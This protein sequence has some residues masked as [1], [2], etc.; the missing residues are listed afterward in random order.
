MALVTPTDELRTL[1][2][3][4]QL[5]TGLLPQCEQLLIQKADPLRRGLSDGVL[6]RSAFES[7][8]VGLR[9]MQNPANLWSAATLSFLNWPLDEQNAILDS[10]G[11]HSPTAVEFISLLDR[12][13]DSLPD[14]SDSFRTVSQ[15]CTENHAAIL[16][17]LVP[18]ECFPLVSNG[19]KKIC[20]LARKL[21]REIAAENDALQTVRDRYPKLILQLLQKTVLVMDPQ[22]H[23]LEKIQ[24]TVDSLSFLL[25]QTNR[26][27]DSILSINPLY[28][29]IDELNP[30]LPEKLD[31]HR[32][33]S[34][35]FTFTVRTIY[36]TA[37]YGYVLDAERLNR[38]NSEL[39]TLIVRTFS[40]LRN[41]FEIH[42]FGGEFAEKVRREI[43]IGRQGQ[44][45]R[46]GTLT[47][48][49]YLQKLE[50]A[51]THSSQH[52]IALENSLNGIPFATDDDFLHDR[53]LL[54]PKWNTDLLRFRLTRFLPT[55]FEFFPENFPEHRQNPVQVPLHNPYRSE[56]LLLH[57]FE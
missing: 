38:L 14:S 8:L 36:F 50:Y 45:I 34:E 4:A 23:Q 49:T 30:L 25:E 15:M 56:R 52:Q 20:S 2:S 48:F 51:A 11:F 47:F 27:L 39:A 5:F 37:A 12:V 46:P 21:N 26:I 44:I 40:T 16:Q 55:T 7:L 13:L 35:L 33:L 24:N 3:N 29:P 9:T 19:V 42:Q 17:N 53:F 54:K 1:L 22:S 18:H 57:R 41:R 31:V 10:R 43:S 6:Q 32:D 28:P